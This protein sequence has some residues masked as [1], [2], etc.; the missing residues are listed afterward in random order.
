MTIVNLKVRCLKKPFWY[1]K[2]EYFEGSIRQDLEWMPMRISI[3]II[4]KR[5]NKP[6][7][8][9]KSIKDRKLTI[10]RH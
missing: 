8:I 2:K 10:I 7:K 3:N 9:I 4:R 6:F 1:K 5:Q